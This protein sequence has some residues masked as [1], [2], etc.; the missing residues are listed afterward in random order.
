MAAN[1]VSRMRDLNEVDLSITV[2]AV[3]THGRR[4]LITKIG[5]VSV[6]TRRAHE[7]DLIC[8]LF[9]AKVQLILRKVD[10]H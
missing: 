9:G 8:I 3:T 4:F 7:G 10:D 1:I 5:I 2:L 6:V